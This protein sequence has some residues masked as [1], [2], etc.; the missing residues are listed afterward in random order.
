MKKSLILVPLA[1]VLAFGY[2]HIA[3]RMELARSEGALAGAMTSSGPTINTAVLM[4]DVRTL[5]SPAFG[6]RRTGSDGSKLAQAYIARRFTEIGL[7]PFGTSYVQPFSFTQT[8]VKALF[9]KDKPYKSEYPSAANIIG[10]IK[11]SKYPDRYMV[12][13]AHYDHLGTRDGKIYAGADDNASGVAA[14]LAVAAAF[15]AQ[16]PE[17]TIVFAAFDAEELGKRG[18]Q[19]FLGS[20]PFGRD[21]LA[22]NLNLDMV[23]RN[24][25]NEIWVSGLYHNPSLKALVQ[26][27]AQRST[28]RVKV[29]HD[30]PIYLAGKV[31][32]WTDSSDHGAFHDAGVPYLYFGV[33]D[34]ADYHQSTDTVEK[35]N[36]DF[37]TSTTSL[38][39]DVV[40]T[41]DS[42]LASVK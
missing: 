36:P 8:S 24:D 33:E 14:M 26:D 10:F 13:S 3:G 31:E 7:Q 34:H 20:L 19:A 37:Y 40:R 42:K 12:V 27:A 11:G 25:S 16:P 39:V 1:A 18:A 35:I 22:L 21:K 38:L 2:F 9:T 5:A 15:K 23:S 30:K 4:D 28:V 32:D 29:G 41:A 17:N 6:G